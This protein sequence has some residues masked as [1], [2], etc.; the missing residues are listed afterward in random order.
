MPGRNPRGDGLLE[1]TG[2]NDSRVCLQNAE[3]NHPG[4]ELTTRYGS[5]RIDNRKTGCVPIERARGAS[6][7]DDEVPFI[8]E[9]WRREFVERARALPRMAPLAENGG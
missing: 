3:G 9:L 1:S 4:D 8:A 5:C 7:V 6:G 2:F